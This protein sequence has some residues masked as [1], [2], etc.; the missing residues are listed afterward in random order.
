MQAKTETEQAKR[1]LRPRLGLEVALFA[2]ADLVDECESLKKK[3]E[4]IMASLQTL[5]R[6][7]R[8]AK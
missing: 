3:A 8:E 7:Q 5:A 6:E 4:H 1:P 2:A